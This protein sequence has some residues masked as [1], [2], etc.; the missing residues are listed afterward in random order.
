MVKNVVAYDLLRMSHI[1]LL[2]PHFQVIIS[3]CKALRLVK[4]WQGDIDI[5]CEICKE[6]DLTVGILLDQATREE[7]MCF[8]LR[9]SFL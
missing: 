1:W 8:V 2:T 6:K 3:F 9:I 4:H 5:R 7:D